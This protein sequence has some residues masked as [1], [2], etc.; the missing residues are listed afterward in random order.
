MKIMNYNLIKRII[1]NWDPVGLLAMGCP[2]DEYNLEVEEIFQFCK[3]THTKQEIGEMIYS[4][5]YNFF[6]EN[7]FEKTIEE[8]FDVGKKILDQSVETGNQSSSTGDG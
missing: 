3:I 4:T 7:T 6:G 2:S 8:C 5:F 1:D